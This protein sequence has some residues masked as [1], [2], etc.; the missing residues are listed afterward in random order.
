VSLPAI[1]LHTD[2]GPIDIVAKILQS[3]IIAG[4]LFVLELSK[5]FATIDR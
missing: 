1:G 4:S 2:V 3:S 5:R